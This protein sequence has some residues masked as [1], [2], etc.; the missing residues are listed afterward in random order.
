[1]GISQGSSE[2]LK[3]SKKAT[4]RTVS[5]ATVLAPAHLEMEMNPDLIPKQGKK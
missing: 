1:M 3:K 5:S 4:F 2:S